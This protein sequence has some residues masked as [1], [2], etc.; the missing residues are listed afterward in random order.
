MS[1]NTN[2][3]SEDIQN[4]Y[5]K[6]LEELNITFDYKKYN[7]VKEESDNGA[8]YGYDNSKLLDYFFNSKNNGTGEYL[9][10]VFLSEKGGIRYHIEYEDN[11]YFTHND[12]C[13]ILSEFN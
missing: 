13:K 12:I 7:I 5:Y 10:F 8:E 6:E 11:K 1:Q 3:I 2:N 4:Q 9:S